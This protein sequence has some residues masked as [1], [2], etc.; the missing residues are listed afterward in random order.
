MLH[1]LTTAILFT[2]LLGI[3][4][5]V[6][7][8]MSVLTTFPEAEKREEPFF[9]EKIKKGKEGVGLLLSESGRRAKITFANLR[10]RRKNCPKKTEEERSFREDFWKNLRED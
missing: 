9:Q 8:K 6:I 7:K 2:S 3:S 4:G 10:D 1:L 5:I